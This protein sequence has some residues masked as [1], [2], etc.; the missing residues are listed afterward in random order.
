MGAY[1]GYYGTLTELS[2]C[3]KISNLYCAKTFYSIFSR[4]ASELCISSGQTIGQFG[5]AS[6]RLGH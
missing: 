2:Q 4:V 6:D 5:A 1:P 3:H